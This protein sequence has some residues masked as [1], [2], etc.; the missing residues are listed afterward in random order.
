[1]EFM[2]FTNMTDFTITSSALPTPG[3]RGADAG[4]RNGAG[5]IDGKGQKWWGIPGVG[6]LER[7]ENR[8]RLVHLNGPSRNVKIERIFFKDPP[9]WT[10]SL[11]VEDGL[12]IADCK[13][14]AWR[15]S[16]D[17]HT[18]IDLS[19]FNTDG[20][21]V[22][23]KNIWIHDCTVW[24]QDDS[25]CIKDGTSDV[26]IENINASGVGL[27]IGSIASNVNNITFRNA[28]M[29][30]TVKGIYMKF[31]GGGTISNVLYENIV[32]DEPE[33]YPI[34]IGP[35]Q[36]SDSSNPCAA[37]PCSLCW[38]QI[39]GAECIAPDQAR[40][41]NVTLRNIV[42]NSPKGNP[43]V[44]LANTSVP[45]QNVVF[46]NVV[47]NNPSTKKTKWGT[48]Y[49]CEGVA[50]GVATGTTS[51]VPPCFKDETVH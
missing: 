10:T 48:N 31:R 3:A 17:S 26:V 7:G 40:Y 9:Y 38:P 25:F 34:W 45:M 41:V 13:I 11:H 24:N 29:H 50:T 36:Q 37:H 23:G 35:A 51:P 49:F 22:T 33:Q 16:H 12:E 19:A 27:T 30:H 46:E 15:I 42:V 18:I 6:Y 47:V 2:S 44:I 20:F 4:A 39:P 5:M 1:M 14:E 32:M 8:P 43:G 28:Y 21:D